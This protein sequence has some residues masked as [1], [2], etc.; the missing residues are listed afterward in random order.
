MKTKEI[1]Y[2]VPVDDV[3]RLKFAVSQFITRF[4]N[5]ESLN[6]IE[7]DILKELLQLEHDTNLDNY[8]TTY[9]R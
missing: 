2:I 5:R 9:T 3:V 8:N 7:I 4:Q 6:I 1:A